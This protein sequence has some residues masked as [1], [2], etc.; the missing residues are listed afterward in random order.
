MSLY[1]DLLGLATAPVT[2]SWTERDTLLYALAVGAGTANPARELDLTT[3]NTDGVAQQVVPTFACMVAS[4]RSPRALGDFDVAKLVHAEQKVVFHRPMSA[5]GTVVA[6]STLV[7]VHDKE[8]AALLV[9]ESVARDPE[10]G[11]AVATSTGTFFVRGEGGFGGDR[12]P[13]P[14]PWSLPDRAP[15]HEITMTTRRDQPLLY[16]LT[17]DRNP[18]HSDPS[19]AARAGF[20]RP[21]MHGMCTYGFTC[22]ALLSTVAQDDPARLRSMSARFSKP[23]MPGDDLVVRIWAEGGTA[24]FQTLDGAGRV[25]LDRGVAE[26]S[27]PK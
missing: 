23:M 15:D 11:E 19:V 8:K 3:E 14:A 18:L 7:D 24:L 25:V 10:T 26:Y 13:V 4:T 12:G 1:L 20:E 16:R 9:Q 22:R 2:R 6:Q 5:S 27:P 17:G 21:I